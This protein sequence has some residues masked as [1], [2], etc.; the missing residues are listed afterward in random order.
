[1]CGGGGGG[2]E[3]RR[4]KEF[5]QLRRLHDEA[6]MPSKKRGHSGNDVLCVTVT[7]GG[8]SR[9]TGASVVPVQTGYTGRGNLPGTEA[10]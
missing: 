9:W 1:M 3:D 10:A 7:A 4:P 8:D 2:V 6:A 5:W